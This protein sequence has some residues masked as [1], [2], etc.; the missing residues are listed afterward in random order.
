MPVGQFGEALASQMIA[1]WSSV[2]GA[3]ALLA[4]THSPRPGPAKAQAALEL[5]R[6]QGAVQK[7]V[8]PPL[9]ATTQSEPAGHAMLELQSVPRPTPPMV[10]PP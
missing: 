10:T 2:D 3:A 4:I 5:E 6:V 8:V 7:P 9:A 1:Q